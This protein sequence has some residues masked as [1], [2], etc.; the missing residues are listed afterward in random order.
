MGGV[1]KNFLKGKKIRKKRNQK[2]Y[3]NI[4]KC[5]Y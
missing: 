3:E 2:R 4:I 1:I 5:L